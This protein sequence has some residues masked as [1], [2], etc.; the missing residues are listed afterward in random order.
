MVI[1]GFDNGKVYFSGNLKNVA[2]T[3][4]N[5][6]VDLKLEFATGRTSKTISLRNVDKLIVTEDI[7]DVVEIVG[8]HPE[9]TSLCGA[10]KETGEFYL[11]AKGCT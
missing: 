6:Y 3:G 7:T 10:M 9:F 1:Q 2:I 5:E 11:I 8:G 4:V